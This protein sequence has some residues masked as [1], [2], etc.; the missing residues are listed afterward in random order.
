MIFLT[1]LE[2]VSVGV[3]SAMNF[4]EYQRPYFQRSFSIPAC[5]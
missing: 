2:V 5:R 4:S 3:I 1:W